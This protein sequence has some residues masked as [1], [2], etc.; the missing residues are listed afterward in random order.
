MQLY[1]NFFKLLKAN[2][3]SVIIATIIM[4]VY[5][6]AMIFAAPSIVDKN[7]DTATEKSVDYKNLGVLFR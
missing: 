3:V 5:G 1:K 7:E 6:V 4:V 2:K